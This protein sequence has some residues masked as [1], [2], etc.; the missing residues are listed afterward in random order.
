ME[1]LNYYDLDTIINHCSMG[2]IDMHE[3]IEVTN[4]L[5]NKKIEISLLKHFLISSFQEI[6]AL[7]GEITSSFVL[8]DFL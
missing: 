7:I 3:P 1:Q 4:K 6:K 8:S 5:K 2:H